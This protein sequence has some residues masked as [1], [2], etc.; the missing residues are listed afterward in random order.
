M[1]KS[2]QA[3]VSG[4]GASVKAKLS[5]IA[6]KGQPEEQLRAPLETLVRE[7]AEVA[8]LPKGTV[9]LV[10]ETTLSGLQTRPDY[11]VTV[12]NAL[13][14]FIEVKAPGK[15]ANPR[16]FSDP[17]DKAQWGKL[18]T[19]PNL[20]Y[21]DGQSF[22]LFH[23]GVLQGSVVALEGDIESAGA[24]LVAPATLL[25]LLTSF[26]QWN[27]T[28]PRSARQLAEVA[29]RLCRFLRD[30]VVEQMGIG[31]RGLS[32]LATAI[33]I[34]VRHQIS[35]RAGGFHLPIRKN[36]GFARP[37]GRASYGLSYRAG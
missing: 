9:H 21:T 14:G 6:I 35:S 23:D 11:A 20:I 15:G 24:K 30:E 33:E 19:L 26:L 3:A 2:V 1:S 12:G 7:L 16:H 36:Q 13:V 18:K 25:P 22:A 5:G 34:E 8:G 27:P 17:H 10:G 32:E 4:F 28:P 31:N 29:A 37:L